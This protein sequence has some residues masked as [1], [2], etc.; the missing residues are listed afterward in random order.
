MSDSGYEKLLNK[1]RAW[2]S[3]VGLFMWEALRAKLTKQQQM[4][5]DALSVPGARVS[6]KAGHGVGKTFFAAGSCLWL[7]TCFKDSCVYCTAPTAAQLNLVLHKEITRAIR[8]MPSWLQELFTD[9]DDLVYIG[10][11]KKDRFIAFRSTANG[12]EQA[13]QGGH[14]KRILFVQEE[15]GGVSDEVQPVIKGALSTP[16][17]RS[18]KI[19]NPVK[20]YGHFYNDFHRNKNN[21][22]LKTFTFSCLDSLIKDGGLVSEEYIDDCRR[23]Y[24]VGSDLWR[25]RVIGEFPRA[26]E[27]Q[28]IATDLLEQAFTRKL[29]VGSQDFAPNILGVD[30]CEGGSDRAVIWHRQGLAAKIMWW[31]YGARAEEI[32]QQVIYFG[33]LLNADYTF[34]DYTGVGSG[35]ITYLNQYNYPVIPIHFGSISDNLELYYNKRAEM[36]KLF[37]QWLDTGGAIHTLDHEGNDISGKIMEEATA[38]KYSLTV[39]DQLQLVR[40]EDIKKEIGVSPDLPDGLVLTFAN[41]ITPPKKT[42]QATTVAVKAQQGYQPCR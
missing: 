36:Y 31:K 41:G 30:V 19:G 25:S 21:P 28:L 3:D 17:A 7:P 1:L 34:V 6:I 13:M 18:L 4:A 40:K 29:A 8:R 16:G 32:G 9:N 38:V 26:G 15:A 20:P 39:K 5:A 23:E 22:R 2:R 33:Q 10:D 11:T 37:E 42:Q 35:T 14:D 27:K 24:G 12:N